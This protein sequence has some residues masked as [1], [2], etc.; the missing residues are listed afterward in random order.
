MLCFC[1]R[2]TAAAGIVM[3]FVTRDW[4]Y[5]TALGTTA[6]VAAFAVALGMCVCE[7]VHAAREVASAARQPLPARRHPYV[8]LVSDPREPEAFW[9]EV[10]GWE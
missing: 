7:A 5:G 1:L 4:R 9:H 2:G 8:V 10:Q 3:A 6:I